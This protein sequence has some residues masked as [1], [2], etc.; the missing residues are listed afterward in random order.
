M[1]NLQRGQE[2]DSVCTQVTECTNISL[3]PRVSVSRECAGSGC[4][5]RGQPQVRVLVVRV[6]HNGAQG[7]QLHARHGRHGAR[8]HRVWKRVGSIVRV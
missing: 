4:P 6:I 8:E 7:G 5:S 1:L 3:S 2:G